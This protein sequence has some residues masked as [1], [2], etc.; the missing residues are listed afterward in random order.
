MSKK[1]DGGQAFPLQANFAGGEYF[2]GND[3]MSLLDYF[4]AHAPAEP[5]YWFVP[6]MPPRPEAIIEDGFCVNAKSLDDYDREYNRQRYIQWPRAWANI[7][8]EERMK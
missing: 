7:M 3:G 5:Q 1:D 2:S 6:E 4:M 8:L